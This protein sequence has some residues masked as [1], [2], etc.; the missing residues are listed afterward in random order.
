[1]QT[2]CL[3]T[4]TRA[5]EMASAEKVRRPEH[6][7]EMSLPEYH[8]LDAN[9]IKAPTLYTCVA[10]CSYSVQIC[11]ILLVALMCAIVGAT[12]IILTTNLCFLHIGLPH[13]NT[14]PT[15]VTSQLSGIPLSRF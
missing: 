15:T 4:I 5:V 8:V 2:S 7:G 1:M 13:P 10:S 3:G 14:L 6:R 11:V 12:S 9:T